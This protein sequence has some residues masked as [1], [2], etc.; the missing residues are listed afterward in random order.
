M[1]EIPEP[2]LRGPIEGVHPLVMPLFFS[3]AQVREDLQ[4]HTAGL[5]EEQV[6]RVIGKT[7]LGFHLQHLSGSVDRLSTYLAGAPLTDRQ[8]Q[9]LRQ[10]G[11][12]GQTLR[13]LLSAVEAALAETEDR[14][15]AIDPAHLYQAR[16]VGRQALPTTVIGLLVHLSEHTQRHL[17]QAITLSQ[18]LRHVP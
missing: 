17:G 11:Q 8:L 3:F 7:S 12:V 18:V 14:L 13:E 9:Q 4:R 10:E 2:W 16:T 1:S 15:H 6:W 5:S